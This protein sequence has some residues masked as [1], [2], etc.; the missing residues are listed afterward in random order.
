M[1]GR[2]EISGAGY[3]RIDISYETFGIIFSPYEGHHIRFEN[4]RT[5]SFPMACG[6]WGIVDRVGLYD[7][8]TGGRLICL[9]TMNNFAEHLI[10]PGCVCE[11]APGQLTFN[12]IMVEQNENH[13]D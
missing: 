9:L 6:I 13:S 7:E 5:V 10:T 8:P 11:F 2:Q 12:S 1:R 4:L 3:H